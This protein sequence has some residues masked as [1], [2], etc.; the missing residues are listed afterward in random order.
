MTSVQGDSVHFVGVGGAGMSA[1]AWLAH[2]GG[3]KVSGCDASTGPYLEELK[4]RG[5]N[6]LI[7]HDV[8]HVESAHSIVVTSAVKSDMPELQAAQKSGVPVLHRSQALARAVEGNRVIAVAGSHGK[9]TTAAMTAHALHAAGIQASFAIGAP[10]RGFPDAVGGGYRGTAKV[11]VIEAD[12]SDGS[13]VAYTPDVAVITNVEPEHLDHFDSPEAVEDAFV[14]FASRARVVIVCADDEGAARVGDRV[15]GRV[16]QTITYGMTPHA[17]VRLLEG[18]V[19]RDGTD[20]PLQV[21]VPGVHNRLNA[22]AAW[23]AATAVEADSRTAATAMR[24]FPGTGRRFEE[25]GRVGDVRVIDDYAHH[26]TEIR[27]LCDAAREHGARSLVVLFQPHLYS[28]TRLLAQEF[29]AALTQP[30]THVIVTGVY[31]AREEPQPGVNAST[32]ADHIRPAAGGTAQAVEDM[33][34]AAQRAVEL[35]SPDTWILTVG[36]GDVTDAADWILEDLLRK[37]E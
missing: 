36:A 14:E 32:I 31:G 24:D 12:E 2:A 6:V 11:A 25:R 9:T 17:D 35:A 27:A 4:A 5:M 16:E 30:D 21:A 29:A 15:R 37:A 23:S 18:A 28:R 26:P 1:V 3:A 34:E 19:R 22:A 7:G 13:F 20:Y 10:V 8:T 33:R